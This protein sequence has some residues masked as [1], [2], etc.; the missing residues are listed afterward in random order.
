MEDLFTVADFALSGKIRARAC[1]SS[2]NYG[3]TVSSTGEIM[4]QLGLCFFL[5]ADYASKETGRPSVCGGA[6]WK[7]V[8]PL[9]V[10]ALN[11]TGCVCVQRFC[12]RYM[13]IASTVE[14]SPNHTTHR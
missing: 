9:L 14:T 8:P 5:Y 12:L 4:M 10:Y 6:V 7:E 2:M 3:S 11:A 13:G 1:S